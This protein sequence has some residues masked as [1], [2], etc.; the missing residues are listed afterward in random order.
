MCIRD[1]LKF[2]GGRLRELRTRALA[3]FDLAGENGDDP[4]RADVQA[5][6]K[7][8]VPAAA[9]PATPSLLREDRRNRDGNH[10]AG[11]QRR[12][13]FTPAQLEVIEWPFIKL[14]T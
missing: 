14:V 10:E 4:V 8:D 5:L 9:S 13:E 6:R 1:S 3:D 12:D 11:A 2:L 7:V